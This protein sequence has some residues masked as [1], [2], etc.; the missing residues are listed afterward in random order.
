MYVEPGCPHCQAAREHFNQAGAVVEECNA[1]ES[2][3]WKG[4]LMGYAGR[5]PHAGEHARFPREL[6]VGVLHH[7]D[8]IAPRIDEVEATTRQD[9]RSRILECASRRLLGVDHRSEVALVVGSLV[10]SLEEPR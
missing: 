2:S 6:D 8:M 3:T 7:L 5:P 4:E 1:T 9:L 10:A